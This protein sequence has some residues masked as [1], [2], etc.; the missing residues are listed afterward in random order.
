MTAVTLL[1][2]GA[3]SG[4]SALAGELAKKWG[5]PVT[6]I[7]TG[8]ARDDEMAARIARHR[9]ER[10]ETWTTVEE[11]IEI[12][13]TI[14]EVAA[15]DLVILDCLTL[16]ASNLMDRGS[17]PRDGEA[18]AREASSA[19][20]RRNTPAIVITNEVGSGIVPDNELARAYRDLL[21]SINSIFAADA[22]HVLFVSAGRVTPMKR[23]DEVID[24]VLDR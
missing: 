16:W 19:L 20:S 24:D 4:K 2:G 8:E 14:A 3:R 5:G 18:R 23:T 21:G 6:F 1:I 7:A 22:T 12:A 13:K 9:D 15:E 10:D 11:P 17:D